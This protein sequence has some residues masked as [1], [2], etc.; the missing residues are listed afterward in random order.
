MLTSQKII[1]Q[2]VS[3]SKITKNL[4]S[5]YLR[6]KSKKHEIQL[7]IWNLCNLFCM[8]ASII[9]SQLKYFSEKPKKFDVITIFT[10]MS[11]KDSD[12][13]LRTLRAIC[14]IDEDKIDRVFQKL[15]SPTEKSL[16]EDFKKEWVP[17]KNNLDTI[18]RTLSEHG[19]NEL[20]PDIDKGQKERY[21]SLYECMQEGKKEK[22]KRKNLKKNKL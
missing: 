10:K 20:Y 13:F 21:P 5:L 9:S 8:I 7:R 16:F 11:G 4:W 22:F 3:L 15:I 2:A 1:D 14:I 17:F 12:F 19:F 6:R 18:S